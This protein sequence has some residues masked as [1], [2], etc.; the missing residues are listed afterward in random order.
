[1]K[2]LDTSALDDLDKKLD[3][4]ESANFSQPTERSADSYNNQNTQQNGSDNRNRYNNRN[5]SR[6]QNEEV[7]EPEKLKTDIMKAVDAYTILGWEETSDDVKDMLSSLAMRLAKRNI[8]LRLSMSD[9]FNHPVKKAMYSAAN[10]VIELYTPWA[11]FLKKSK[12][13]IK[14][15]PDDIISP[16]PS[17]QAHKY[18]NELLAAR[19]DTGERIYETL[20]LFQKGFKANEVQTLLGRN[21]KQ[22]VKFILYFGKE[23]YLASRIAKSTGAALFDV[24]KQGFLEEFINYMKTIKGDDDE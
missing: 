24:T 13:D 15:D 12:F 21:L 7:L 20:P 5:N 23:P 1:M 18:A 2:E 4:M 14:V 9:N 10:P 22:P 16:K 11:T 19:K 3:A 6:D 8:V 17:K